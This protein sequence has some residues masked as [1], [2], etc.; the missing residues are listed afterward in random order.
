MLIL[1]LAEEGEICLQEKV[2]KYIELPNKM[3]DSILIHQ[4]LTHTSGLPDHNSVLENNLTVHAKVNYT[5]DERIGQLKNSHLEFKPGTDWSYN[6]FGYSLLAEIASRI[7]GEPIDS[8][9]FKY[10]FKPLNMSNSGTYTDSKVISKRAFGYQWDSKGK[11]IRPEYNANTHAKIGGGGIYSTSH[12]LLIWYKALY[13]KTLLSDK[14]LEKIITP[15]YY[16]PDS[17]GYSYGFYWDPYMDSGKEYFAISHGGSLPGTSSLVCFIPELNQCIILLN[18]TGMGMEV[19]LNQI[20][21]EILNILN[22]GSFEYPALDVIYALAYTGL[23]ESYQNLIEQYQYFKSK[24]Q[25]SA[26]I[27]YPEQLVICCDLLK[28][29]GKTEGIEDI[30]NF[31]INEFPDS[32]FAYLGLGNYY[33]E[34]KRYFEA[35]I[36]YKK[37]LKQD[38]DEETQQ[39]IKKLISECDL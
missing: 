16:F 24:N 28:R 23:F 6:G 15:Q 25:A 18:N 4:L 35:K 8:L 39:M 31:N 22:K 17:T 37:A 32:F 12:D 2:S 14:Y 38:V 7:K 13:N 20:S 5:M 11:F 9:F 19:F 1:Q 21:L 10:I 33:K 3:G 36:E 34:K 26:Y 27:F 29:Y 30:L